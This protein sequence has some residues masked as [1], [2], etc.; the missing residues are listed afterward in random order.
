MDL[1]YRWLK[2]FAAMTK[3]IIQWSFTKATLSK[4]T[5]LQFNVNSHN[6][7]LLLI[8]FNGLCF[9]INITSNTSK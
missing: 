7:N 8:I 4:V 2:K 6:L 9:F 5:V 3:V 1:N